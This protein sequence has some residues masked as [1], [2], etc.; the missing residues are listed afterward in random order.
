[1]NRPGLAVAGLENLKRRQNM[2]VL[3]NAFTRI[4]G[5]DWTELVEIWGLSALRW[6]LIANS[7]EMVPDW[8][9]VMDMLPLLEAI[10]ERA[11]RE[12]LKLSH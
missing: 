4:F 10:K 11:V 2:P 6:V 1:V 5:P 8:Q 12:G 9:R 3:Y 7:D